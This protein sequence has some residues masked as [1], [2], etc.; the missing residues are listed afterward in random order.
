M[1]S[2]ETKTR[3]D[4]LISSAKVDAGK[5]GLLQKHVEQLRLG[6][7]VTSI[8]PK[9]QEQIRNLLDLSE[10]AC[11]KIRQKRVLNSLAYSDMHGRFETVDTAHNKTFEWIFEDSTKGGNVDRALSSRESFIHWLSAG[12]GIFHI[13]GKLGSGKSTLMKFLCDHPRTE[14]ELQEWAGMLQVASL[15]HLPM[16]ILSWLQPPVRPV[17]E[18]K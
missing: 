1:C 14:A 4:T 13:T 16:C 17:R 15:I 7:R 8:S 18:K 11:R 5:L 3:L 9:A 2:S 10:E 12:S 6:V